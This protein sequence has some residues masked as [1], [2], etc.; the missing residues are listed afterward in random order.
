MKIKG[1]AENWFSQQILTKPLL[2]TRHCH[3]AQGVYI[4]IIVQKMKGHGVMTERTVGPL[5]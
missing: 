5:T 3:Q 4:V 2:D 1:S